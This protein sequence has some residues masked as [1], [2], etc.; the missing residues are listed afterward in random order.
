M[1][2]II[3]VIKHST[4]ISESYK[5]ALTGRNIVSFALHNLQHDPTPCIT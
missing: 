4:Y 2:A 1:V 3:I 5:N